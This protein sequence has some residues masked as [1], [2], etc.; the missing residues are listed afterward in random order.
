[1]PTKEQ[2]KEMEI[3]R[4]IPRSWEWLVNF[5]LEDMWRAV[6]LSLLIG[7]MVWTAYT[8]K[9]FRQWQERQRLR[10]MRMTPR[11]REKWFRQRLA[12]MIVDVIENERVKGTF[13]DKECARG[14][15]IVTTFSKN[16]GTK[17]PGLMPMQKP[18][19][20]DQPAFTRLERLKN[21][22]SQRTSKF[23]KLLYTPKNIPGP[24]PIEEVKPN[25]LP[26]PKKGRIF[27]NTTLAKA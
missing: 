17:I 2:K 16:V 23:K 13:T 1:V 10:G 7:V 18:T 22:I 3:E 21:E 9:Q 11:Q 12:D 5:T 15:R 14:Y 19:Q 27:K 8:Q 6:A 26:F 4:L 24:K 20:R 25:K